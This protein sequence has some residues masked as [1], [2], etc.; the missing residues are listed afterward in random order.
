MQNKVT[1]AYINVALRIGGEIA[2]F[3]GL[4]TTNGRNNR[5]WD[6]M[7]ESDRWDHIVTTFW[8][9]NDDIKSLVAGCMATNTNLEIEGLVF[10]A[11]H[12]TRLDYAIQ[13]RLGD[14]I[15]QEF[16]ESCNTFEMMTN[17]ISNLEYQGQAVWNRAFADED[18][19]DYAANQASFVNT[20]TGTVL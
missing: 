18:E 11:K 15:D 6:E 5:T 1:E 12:I 17:A 2:V 20:R 7:K 19:D 13:A 8:E 9:V 4:S 3:S 14:L 10:T 16:V